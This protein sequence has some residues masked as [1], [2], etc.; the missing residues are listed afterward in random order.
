L[1]QFLAA[2]DPP[3][4]FTLG[5]TAVNDPGA[6]YEESAAAAARMRRRAVLLVGRG[7]ALRFEGGSGDVLSVGYTPHELLFPRA[8]AIVHQGGIGTLSEGLRSGKPMLIMPYAHDQADNAWRASRLGIAKIMPRRQYKATNLHRAITHILDE[9][10]FTGAGLRV[11]Q[12]VSRERGPE[13]A[14]T[15]IETALE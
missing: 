10:S 13:T 12:D 15:L 1:D 9:P 6:F 8:L 7:H 11:A 4:V 5:T 14:A 2:G 3:L